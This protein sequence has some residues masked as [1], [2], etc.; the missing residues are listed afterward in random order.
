VLSLN[1]QGHRETFTVGHST[2]DKRT[3]FGPFG[4]HIS[5]LPTFFY[6]P[7][8]PSSFVNIQHQLQREQY[9]HHNTSKD[10]LQLEESHPT[11]QR[12][13]SC[14]CNKTC[15]IFR[16][17]NTGISLSTRREL[18][19]RHTVQDEHACWQNWFRAQHSA[20]LITWTPLLRS[21]LPN[22]STIAVVV[23]NTL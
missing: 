17:S 19:R 23:Q 22:G 2:L 5:Q 18:H 7:Q 8:A 12:A 11:Q 13:S 20:T 10:S 6:H 3:R 16:S 21:Q 4:S 14:I 9:Q 15:N 1:H